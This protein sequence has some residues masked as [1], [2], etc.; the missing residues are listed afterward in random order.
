MDLEKELLNAEKK[1]IWHCPVCKNILHK[2]TKDMAQNKFLA[3]G[4]RACHDCEST[5][6]MQKI[7]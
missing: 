7:R 1:Q 2:R 4:I 3:L 5:W 6:V